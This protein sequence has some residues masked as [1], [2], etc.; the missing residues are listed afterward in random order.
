MPRP[1]KPTADLAARG[2]F[3]KDPQRA[4]AREGEPEG[5]GHLPPPPDYFNDDQR[6]AWFE[7]ASRAPVGV[8]TGSDAHC[9]ELMACI[10]VNI[11]TLKGDAPAAMFAQ[12]RSYS[13]G[14]GMTPADRSRI[15]LGKQDAANPF[16]KF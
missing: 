15:S 6:A 12:F 4:R 2:A 10:L 5:N 1:R 7:L 14:F 11:R 8:I 16:S 13:A 3:K 9:L